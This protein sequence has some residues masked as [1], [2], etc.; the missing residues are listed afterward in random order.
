MLVIP[1]RLYT[2]TGATKII[3]M[4]NGQM[5]FEGKPDGML[6]HPELRETYL[7]G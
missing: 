7:G 2:V 1:H 4:E 5:A 6:E 3:V